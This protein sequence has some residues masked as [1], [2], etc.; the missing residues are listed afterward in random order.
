MDKLI[1]YTRPD[2]HLC[3]QAEEMV[4]LLAPALSLELVD[5]EPDLDLI[6]RYGLSIPVL[7]KVPEGD[8]LAW[9]FDEAGLAGFLS[10]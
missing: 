3:E 2:C 6:S 5:I 7:A 1:L 4:A 10:T 8:E 9:P